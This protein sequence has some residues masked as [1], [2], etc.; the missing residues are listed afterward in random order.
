[1]PG[2]LTDRPVI[3]RLNRAIQHRVKRSPADQEVDR[4]AF[5]KC[6]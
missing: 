1:M 6:S 2:T 4:G 5:V 3:L